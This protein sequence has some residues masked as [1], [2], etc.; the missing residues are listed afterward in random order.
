L[1]PHAGS[2]TYER[3]KSK[4]DNGNGGDSGNGNGSGKTRLV[5][6]AGCDRDT[7]VALAEAIYLCR[8]MITTVRDR[9]LP[10]F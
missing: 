8:D 9:W 5:W 10:R 3:Y 4:K 2:Y 6:P 1:H 7:V